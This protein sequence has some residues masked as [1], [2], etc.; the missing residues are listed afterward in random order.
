MYRRVTVQQEQIET[1]ERLAQCEFGFEEIPFTAVTAFDYHEKDKLLL[2]TQTPHAYVRYFDTRDMSTETR[3]IIVSPDDFTQPLLWKKDQNLSYM[4]FLIKEKVDENYRSN[5]EQKLAHIKQNY[6][7]QK[8]LA[9]YLLTATEN[10]E[11]IDYLKAYLEV[12]PLG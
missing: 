12:E 7:T 1:L 3:G 8:L 4:T 6:H 9:E 5:V 2:Y 11:R 10:G